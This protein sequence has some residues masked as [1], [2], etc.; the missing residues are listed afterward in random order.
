MTLP[1][2]HFTDFL[3]PVV[4]QVFLTFFILA[5]T[6]VYRVS[7]VRS[8]SVRVRDIAL[9]SGNWPDRVRQFGNSFANQFELPVL[10]MPLC[11]VM[12]ALRS[13]DGLLYV[14]AWAFFA[15]RV[16]HALIHVTSN[17]VMLRFSAYVA[18][19]IILAGM[20]SRFAFLLMTGSFV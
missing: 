9:N 3:L 6:G 10:V 7:A 2:G 14:L 15:S 13:W 1:A 5:L 12:V 17:H 19:G 11:V 20:W 16:V 4:A 18:G 8:R